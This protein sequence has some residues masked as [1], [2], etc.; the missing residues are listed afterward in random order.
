MVASSQFR[1][2]QWLISELQRVCCILVVFR[3]VCV[4]T[5]VMLAFRRSCQCAVS[6]QHVACVA[7]NC[8][9]GWCVC[10]FQ[11]T[12]LE[13]IARVSYRAAYMAAE[14]LQEHDALSSYAAARISR[15]F[16]RFRIA[17]LALM[18]GEIIP[19][20]PSWELTKQLDVWFLSNP[21]NF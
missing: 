11:G 20:M 17:R 9:A 6:S 13:Q 12:D 15:P 8:V 3:K 2:W 16:K 7:S 18:T 5:C 10:L 4:I 14:L 1:I 21:S 19:A